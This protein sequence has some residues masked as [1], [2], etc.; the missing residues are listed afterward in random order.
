M[1]RI[2][3]TGSIAV[4][5]TFVCDVFAELG[6]EVLDADYVARKV[7][8][9]NTNGLRLI[10]ENFGVEVLQDDASLDR[11]KLGEIVF[12]NELKRQLLNNIVHPI[13]I[14]EQN[15][16]LEEVE[17]AKPDGI[18]IVDAALL[19]E[20]GGYKRFD[21]IIVVWCGSDIQLKRLMLRNNLSKKE[22]LKRIDS[23]LSQEEK[24]RYSDFLIDTTEGFEVT[25]KQ[26]SEVFKELKENLPKKSENK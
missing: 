17:S 7:V 6:C 16:W 24:K 19:I 21:K 2:G 11:V 18:A 20:S 10:I 13:V 8:E 15:K 9:P 22:A 26:T 23:Q 14:E 25:R 5:K 12:N 4:G 1:L 3:L